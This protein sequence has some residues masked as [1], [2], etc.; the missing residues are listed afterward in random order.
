MN[1]EFLRNITATKGSKLFW[2]S[3]DFHKG[4]TIGKTLSDIK[5]EVS[6]SFFIF[7]RN[8]KAE[9]GFPSLFSH[10]ED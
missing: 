6:S 4:M 9:K 5:F 8:R 7:C 2:E 10:R 3:K 1:K